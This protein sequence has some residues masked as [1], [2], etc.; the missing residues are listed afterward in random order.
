VEWLQVDAS[1]LREA[2]GWTPPRSVE[3]GLIGLVGARRG[4]SE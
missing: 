2:V 1:G 4:R 3:Q